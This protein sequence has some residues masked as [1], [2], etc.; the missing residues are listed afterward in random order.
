MPVEA[1]FVSVYFLFALQEKL[2]IMVWRTK[3]RQTHILLE[4]S[5]SQV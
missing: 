1:V 3:I 2:H 5:H 4:G